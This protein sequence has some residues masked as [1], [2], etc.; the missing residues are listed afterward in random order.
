MQPQRTSEP[1]PEIGYLVIQWKDRPDAREPWWVHFFYDHV[2]VP[3]Q[4]FSFKYFNIPRAKQR[5]VEVLPDGTRRETYSWFENGGFFDSSECADLACV[6]EQDGYKPVYKNRSA[7]RESAE[8][9]QVVFPRSKNPK[10]WA[11]PTLSLIVKDRKQDEREQ[12][13]WKECLRRLNQILDQ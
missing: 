13:S 12:Q 8:I 3:F 4:R 6:D 2:Y 9:G 11:K 10:R 5:T 1:N 7:P